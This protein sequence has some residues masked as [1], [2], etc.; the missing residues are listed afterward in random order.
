MNA[1]GNFQSTNQR[2][3]WDYTS[4]CQVGIKHCQAVCW[5]KKVF[6]GWHDISKNSKLVTLCFH[7]QSKGSI[8]VNLGAVQAQV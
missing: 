5:A 1:M 3:G 6:Q 2:Y 4:Y 7:L 8:F